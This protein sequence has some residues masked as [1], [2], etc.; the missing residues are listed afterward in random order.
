ML[1]L[2]ASVKNLRRK[3]DQIPTD[4]PQILQTVTAMRKASFLAEMDYKFCISLSCQNY[5]THEGSPF[6]NV[7]LDYFLL[8]FEKSDVIE[9]T[10][11]YL[12]IFEQDDLNTLSQKI[13]IKINQLE[14]SQ[15]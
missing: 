4:N 8:F 15:Y 5:P 11:V 9:D 7:V 14:N 6:Y 13:E 1:N 10:R 2:M 12:Q 3:V